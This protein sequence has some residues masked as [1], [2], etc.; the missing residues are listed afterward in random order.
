MYEQYR[1]LP[2]LLPSH[3]LPRIDRNAFISNR[4]RLCVDEAL[5]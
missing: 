1:A 5:D 4:Q 2:C 3:D